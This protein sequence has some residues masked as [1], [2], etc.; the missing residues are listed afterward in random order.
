MM[1]QTFT[2]ALL[3]TA[4]FTNPFQAAHPELARQPVVTQPSASRL[5]AIEKH[6]SFAIE[7]YAMQHQQSVQALNIT[8][9]C[10]SDQV[11]LSPKLVTIYDEINQFLSHYPNEDDYWEVINRELAQSLLQ[12]HPELSSISI[13]L[14]ILPTDRIPYPRASTVTQS[15]S[16]K[17]L[18]SWQ[19]TARIPIQVQ[20]NDLR[21]E[22]EYLYRDGI[23][24]TEY[25]DF[26]PIS[27]RTTQL[28]MTAMIKGEPWE[29]ANQ[30][31]AENIL[32]KYPVLNSFTSHLENAAKGGRRMM[33][34]G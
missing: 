6:W 5:V 1:I 3:S 30:V 26:V 17:V 33:D 27:D 34:D 24:N 2:H 13:M 15:R 29:Y 4:I 19:F 31:I 9:D 22:V 21:Y 28:L 12:E 10:I 20:G 16:G 7:R 25:P 11:A 14:E 23:T 8:V 32:K 18:E